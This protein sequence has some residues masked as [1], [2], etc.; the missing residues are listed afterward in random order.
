[1]SD[2]NERKKERKTAK[3]R[4]NLPTVPPNSMGGNNNDGRRKSI[5]ERSRMKVEELK[6]LPKQVLQQLHDAETSLNFMPGMVSSNNC[7]NLADI[8]PLL[9]EDLVPI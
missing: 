5:E 9:L 2:E 8:P 3:R 7:A 6:R 4:R 1:M